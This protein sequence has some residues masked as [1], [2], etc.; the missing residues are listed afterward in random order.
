M[1]PDDIRAERWGQTP[2]TRIAGPEEAAALIGRVGIATLFPASPEFADLYAAFVGPG[3]PTDS[4]HSTPSGEVYTWRWELGRREVAFYGAVVR[5]KPTWVAWDLLPA[6]LRLLGDARPLAAQVADGLLSDDS[7]RVA[8]ALEGN[9]GALTTGDLRRLAGFETGR[10]RRA[11]YLRAIAELDRRLLIGRGF[12]PPDEP[13][14]HDMRQLLIAPRHPDAIA[15][16]DDLDAE[17]AMR[18]VL[19]RYLDGAAFIRPTIFARHL[20]LEQGSVD[21]SL[22]AMTTTGLVERQRP[23]GEQHEIYLS[24]S[25]TDPADEGDS[26]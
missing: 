4:G 20:R 24:P 25:V 22:A 15:A 7:R 10:E 12:G 26:R 9:G 11:A 21:R 2:A 19:T 1:T 23:T 5:G 13:D 18:H 17:T 16:A 14:D 8:E 6:L 3:V